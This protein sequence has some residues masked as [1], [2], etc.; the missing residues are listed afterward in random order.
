MKQRREIIDMNKLDKGHP[1]ENHIYISYKNKN[2]IDKL[3][4]GKLL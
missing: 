2:H 4:L 3:A 1:Q